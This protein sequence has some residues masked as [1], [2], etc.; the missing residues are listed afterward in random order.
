MAARSWSVGRTMEMAGFA[1]ASA[2]RRDERLGIHVLVDT[3]C[4]RWLAC[5]VRDALVPQRPGGEVLVGALDEAPGDPAEA[6]AALFLVRGGS[7]VRVARDYVACGVPV[8][9]VVEDALDTP[10][11]PEVASG[12]L[13]L[14]AGS[15]E[16]AL[17]D[18]LSSWLSSSVGKQV[19]LGANFPFCRERVCDAL[20]RRCALQNAGVCALPFA[21]GSDFPVMTANQMRLA[22]D[23]SAAN[24]RG[25]EAARLLD[26]AGV[27][28][29][30]VVS[31]AA[32]RGLLSVLPGLG[33]LVRSGVAAGGTLVLGEALRLR[34]SDGVDLPFSRPGAT[35]PRSVA[36]IA[37][38]TGRKGPASS[39]LEYMIIGGEAS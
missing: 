34:F 13:A 10:R 28:A 25:L 27:L 16:D 19:A 6:D 32:A 39:A 17:L 9:L 21:S 36:T 26:L 18:R 30:A 2:R 12:D 22:L 5:A 31:R 20:V 7:C 3:D 29:G 38:P 14:V 37:A 23:L 8:A 15:D 1:R 35:A 4:P 24:G 11:L 33:L